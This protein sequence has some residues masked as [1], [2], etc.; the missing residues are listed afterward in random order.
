IAARLKQ[1]GVTTSWDFG[2]DDRLAADPW[3]WPLATSV[4]LM[5]VNRDETMLYA[6]RHNVPE[7]IA[8][9]R[10]VRN[11]VVIKLGK[12][13]ARGVGGG[14]GVGVS[15]MKVRRVIDTTGEGDAL[16]GGFLAALL[17]GRSIRQALVVGNRLGALSLTKPGGIAGLP[18][19]SA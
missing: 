19:P 17:R 12:D 18:C 6:R 14:V 10:A 1:R 3:L 2:W 11:H 4:D 5:F 13:G 9:W 8:R 7:A 15:R 16:N